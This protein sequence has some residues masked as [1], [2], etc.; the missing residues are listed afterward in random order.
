M[1]VRE[2]GNRDW[3]HIYPFGEDLGC[4]ARSAGYH[5]IQFNAVVETNTG[6]V[7]LWES[8]GFEILTTVP[9]TFDHSER[10]LVGL[11]VMLRQLGPERGDGL[12]G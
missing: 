7:W 6:A 3:P 12:G 10:G 1:I 9:D 4:W 11:H 5:S 8:L 2:A